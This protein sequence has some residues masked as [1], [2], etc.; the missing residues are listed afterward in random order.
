M[1]KTSVPNGETNAN[2]TSLR[3][4]ILLYLDELQKCIAAVK[5]GNVGLAVSIWYRYASDTQAIRELSEEQAGKPTATENNRMLAHNLLWRFHD[6]AVKLLEATAEKLGMDSTAIVQSALVCQRL[7][8]DFNRW[9]CATAETVLWPGCIGTNVNRLSEQERRWVCESE[10]ALR[11]LLARVGVSDTEENR[12]SRLVPVE[13]AKAQAVERCEPEA[14]PAPKEPEGN[15]DMAAA[16]AFTGGEMVFYTDHVELCRATICVPRSQTRRRILDLLRTKRGDGRFQWYSGTELAAQAGLEG[17]KGTVAG[18][19]RD[20]RGEIIESLA[21]QTKLKCG[22]FD[23]I[24]SGGPG[25]RFADCVTVR[26]GEMPGSSEEMAVDRGANVP[27]V[28]NGNVPNVPDVP[29][30]DVPDV[31][32]GDVPNVPE[33]GAEHV[34]DRDDGPGNAL[35]R[36]K[37]ILDRLAEGRQLQA[38]DVAAQFKCSVRTA[39]RDLGELK[40]EGKIEFVGNRRTG[41]YRPR[42]QPGEGR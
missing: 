37:W 2:E 38:P 34:P 22:R 21:S 13:L 5:D 14:K 15:D 11:R 1:S 10:A 30:G 31:P 3:P 9:R 16:S 23:V 6:E 24:L 26:D 19:I 4:V 29:N 39:K 12:F 17:G 20:L 35:C 25:Y 18:A 32:N 8:Q 33:D 7:C 41:Y 42:T 27:D 28:P 36:R 40:E